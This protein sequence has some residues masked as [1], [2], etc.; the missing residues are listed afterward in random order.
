[1]SAMPKVI[2]FPIVSLADISAR[3]R[4]LAD[5]V[6]AGRYGEAKEC[7]VTLHADQLEVFAFGETD[8]TAAHYLLACAQRKLEQP[9]LDK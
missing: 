6:E 8:G 7:V 4:K 2:E 3:L 1:M 5:D 9:M